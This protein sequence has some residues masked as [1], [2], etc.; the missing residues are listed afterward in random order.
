MV[1]I[2][3]SKYKT[4]LA[5]LMS[6]LLSGCADVVA[7]DA[8]NVDIPT[9]V[10]AEKRKRATNE[11]PDSV[12]Y[13]PLG[14]DVLVPETLGGDAFPTEQVGP[15]ELRG[16][17]LAGALQLILAEY[18]ISL[19]FESQEGL[20][21]KI[22]VSNLK[23]D[24]GNVVDRVCSLA[25]LY[26]SFE[27]NTIT[28]KDT[29]TFTVTMPPIGQG[30][31]PT[32]YLDDVAKGLAAILGTNGSAPIVDPSTRTIVYTA[33]A[34][35]AE[36][37]SKYF[38]RLRANTAMIVFETYIWEV[39][40]DSG[41]STG[42]DWDMIDSF[43]KFETSLSLVGGAATDFTNPVS[44]GLPTTK[45]VGASPTDLVEF[46]SQFGAV[47]TIS[48]PQITVLS[49]S[50]AELRVADT[51]NYVSQIS[52]TI[53]DS[54]STTS[55]TT[56]SVDSG[57]TLSIGSS[58][59]KSTVY[60]NINIDLTNVISIDDF[61]FS[62]GGAGGTSTAIQ[63]PQTTQRELTTQVRVRPGDSILIA[64]LVQEKDNFSSRGPGFMEPV[65]PDSR[66][67]TTENLELVF[68]LRPRVV[69]YSA[70][71]AAPSHAP[72]VAMKSSPVVPAAAS[73]PVTPEM[74]AP[75]PVVEA[76]PVLE[77]I[78]P[79]AP[80]EK[81]A[82]PVM[83][84]PVAPTPVR[85]VSPAVPV[86]PVSRAPS[87]PAAPAPLAPAALSAVSTPV[88]DVPETSFTP[89]PLPAAVS[90]PAPV[91]TP[92]TTPAVAVSSSSK[93]EASYKSVR[94]K[95]S[96]RTYAGSNT[97]VKSY[98]SRIGA[99]GASA[100]S[101]ATSENLSADAVEIFDV[102]GDSAASAPAAVS[103]ENLSTSGYST[104]G[105]DNPSLYD[106]TEYKN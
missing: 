56:D 60:A 89:D 48:Q 71:G 61:T 63:L 39:S 42:I 81:A 75:A 3:G 58:W 9:P 29:Q 20:S 51:Q 33:T 46:L 104:Y 69:V 88:V 52:T 103:R 55:A 26:C 62:D 102:S 67:A 66:T 35:S 49:G 99:S 65:I 54:Q 101:A 21:R 43:G 32:A 80:V 82:A 50:S 97:P 31:T 15:F 98:G 90:A 8:R 72:A 30:E 91:Q 16:E 17:T 78:V 18:D 83:P 28:V 64:G 2:S 41:N 19:A 44:I 100:A 70:A 96:S 4:C 73:V 5:V 87:V 12:M 34:R 59:D 10:A 84:A 11:R 53:S 14:E 27:N 47:K 25:N 1:L 86:L 37:A 93:G 77:P 6:L 45:S 85:S 38:Q 94:P 76:A 106:T 92:V 36:L 24:L 13:L 57:F 23:G 74:P 22:T 68:L 79:P 95:I 7:P 105:S 40:L